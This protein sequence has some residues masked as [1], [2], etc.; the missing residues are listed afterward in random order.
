MQKSIVFEFENKRIEYTPYGETWVDICKNTGLLYLPYKFTGKELDEET[1]LYYYGARYLD[2]KY[3]LWKSTDPALGEYMSGSDAGE[4]GVYNHI[5]L[6]LYHYAGNNPIRSVDPDGRAD[7]I[8]YGLKHPFIANDLRVIQGK[9]CTNIGTNAVRFACAVGPE[10]DNTTG[11]IVN[12]IRHTLWASSITVKYG[13]TTAKEATDSHEDNPNLVGLM[14]DDKL[15]ADSRADILNNAIG[16]KIG[17]KEG[18]KLDM[19]LLTKRVLDYYSSEGLYQTFETKD[20]K[21]EVKKIK[22]S[23]ELYLNALQELKSCNANGFRPGDDY[24]EE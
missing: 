17:L 11:G 13:E 22:L 5:N 2:P 6:N 14:F 24:Y 7:E 12:A 19:K 18:S 1:G 8:K 16:I 3:S 23:W 10:D 4:G 20:G 9:G 21:W 15:E